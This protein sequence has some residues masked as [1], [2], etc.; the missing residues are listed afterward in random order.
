MGV[1]LTKENFKPDLIVK[2]VRF[3]VDKNDPGGD[4]YLEMS[5]KTYKLKKIRDD[6]NGQKCVLYDCCFNPFIWRFDIVK[7]LKKRNLNWGGTNE[8]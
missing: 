3:G 4:S 5:N 6:S 8:D 7:G 2:M 1:M